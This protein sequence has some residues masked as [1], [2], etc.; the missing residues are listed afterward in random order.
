M[1]NQTKIVYVVWIFGSCLIKLMLI[2]DIIG[3]HQ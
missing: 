1:F 2:L 3:G